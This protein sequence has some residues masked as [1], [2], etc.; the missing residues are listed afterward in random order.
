MGTLV[1]ALLVVALG[2]QVVALCLTPHVKITEPEPGVAVIET[3]ERRRFWA[4]ILAII[5]LILA[6]VASLISAINPVG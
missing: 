1:I 6:T 4:T 2:V 3:F 5:G